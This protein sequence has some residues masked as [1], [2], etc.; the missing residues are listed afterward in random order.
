MPSPPSD[1]TLAAPAKLNL[2]LSVGGPD[3]T[4][5]HPLA[6]WMV[7]LDFG[8]TVTLQRTEGATSFDIAYASDAP[9][10]AN[11]SID[12]PLE[13]DLARQAHQAVERAVG[14]TLPVWATIRKRVP[15]GM[16]LGGGSSDA[17]AMLVGLAH[18]FALELP[19]ERLR[20][21]AATLGSDVPFLVSALLE[22]QPAGVVTG[23]GE[24]VAL[25]PL[26]HSL[27]LVLILPALHCPTAAVYQAFDKWHP[28]A[29]SAQH[30]LV[31]SLAQTGTAEAG[32][33]FNALGPPA[34]MVEPALAE[35][36][37]RIAD[38]VDRPVLITG[39]GGGLFVLARDENEARDLAR[40]IGEA[41]GVA[42]LPARDR[43]R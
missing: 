25:M 23:V 17:A 21:I 30:A 26:E 36:R 8:D 16:G 3:A 22:H 12:W 32:S 14:R 43:Q 29:G 9:L 31:T 24:E 4:G 34:L 7:A 19:A 37:E 2:A 11:E 39:S 13:A 40:R 10:H 27:H 18:L 20:A 5:Y 1:I 42:A 35:L 15:P 28:D 38:V 33:L 41:T 6:S